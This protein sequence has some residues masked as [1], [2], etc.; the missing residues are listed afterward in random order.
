MKT[1]DCHSLLLSWR[2]TLRMWFNEYKV[3]RLFY[4]NFMTINMMWMADDS[5][6]YGLFK[7]ILVIS[8]QCENGDEIVQR[9]DG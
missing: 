9:L 2:N 7:C 5:V 4:S 1:Y 6:F 3:S 8:G